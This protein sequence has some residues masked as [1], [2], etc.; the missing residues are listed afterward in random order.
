MGSR[1]VGE[2]VVELA[3][4]GIAVQHDIK[5]SVYCGI[6]KFDPFYMRL[7]S[8]IAELW[9]QPYSC[10]MN[11]LWCTISFSLLRSSIQCIRGARS[12]RGHFVNSGLPVD[13]VTVERD[14]ES[15]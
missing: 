5:I 8:S 2:Q 9:D 6:L 3:V 10:I 4:R 14:L 12:S 1:R 7:A 15:G 11:W 13:L